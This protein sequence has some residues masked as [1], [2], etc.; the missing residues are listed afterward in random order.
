MIIVNYY[1]EEDFNHETD[2]YHLHL[3][4]VINDSLDLNYDIQLI[5]D[6]ID[7]D[8]DFEPKNGILYELQLVR[9][10]ISADPIPEPAFAIREVIELKRCKHTGEFLQE[11]VRL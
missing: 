2:G 3:A 6:C 8:S 1:R 10:T 7:N 9:A 11:L 5:I 4:G